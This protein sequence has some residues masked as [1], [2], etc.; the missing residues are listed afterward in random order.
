MPRARAADALTQKP[1]PP[2]AKSEHIIVGPADFGLGKVTAAQRRVRILR[3][4]FS[5]ILPRDAS[6]SISLFSDVSSGTKPILTPGQRGTQT[7][8]ER[9]AVDPAALDF[10]AVPHGSDGSQVGSFLAPESA[11]VISPAS[12]CSPDLILSGRS[13]PFTIPVGRRQGYI[14][15]CAPQNF[16]AAPATF[17]FLAGGNWP[18]IQ[19]LNKGFDQSLHRVDLSWEISASPDVIG[20]NVYRGQESGGPYA[21]INSALL[22]NNAYTDASVADGQTYYYVATAV[23]SS[24]RESVYS[25]EVPA[26]IP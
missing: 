24:G 12:A 6:A 11:M 26:P 20:Y 13:L 25:N 3:N 14:V 8:D 4:V 17:S 7:D 18:A 22:A 5:R 10:A 19:A 23:D 16:G 21:R 2:R 1:A 9:L 15:T